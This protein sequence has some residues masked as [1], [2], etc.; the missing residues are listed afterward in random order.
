MNVWTQDSFFGRES[1]LARASELLKHK[2]LLVSG[3]GGIGKTALCHKLI[4]RTS[5]GFTGGPLMGGFRDVHH[6]EHVIQNSRSVFTTEGRRLL[7]VDDVPAGSIDSTIAVGEHYGFTCLLASRDAGHAQANAAILPL[8]ALDDAAIL[9]FLRVSGVADHNLRPGDL[10][11][12]AW[13]SEGHPLSLRLMFALIGQH[14]DLRSVLRA[15]DDTVQ[16]Q[17]LPAKT[18]Q[19]AKLQ[20]EVAEFNAEIFARL[21]Q[22]PSLI[23]CLSPRRFEEL[24]AELLT[25][26]G[27]AVSLTPPTKDGGFDI[28]AARKDGLG[29]FLYLVECKKYTPPNQV[30]VEIVRSLHGVVQAKRATAG[31]L[32]TTSF[33]TRGAAEFQRELGYQMHLHDFNAIKEWLVPWAPHLGAV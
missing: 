3:P 17:L 18:K 4:E 27:Y 5:D 1:E 20:L 26:Q 32:V 23:R 8:G 24:V 10:A 31:A 16:E 25:R 19:S 28:Y 7:F 11:E 15:W 22:E 2:H 6:L 30:G 13:R 21:S 33:F 12:I 14:G 9:Q 29:S